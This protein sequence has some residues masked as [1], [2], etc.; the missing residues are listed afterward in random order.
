M[1][2]IHATWD[3]HDYGRNDAGAEFVAK[4]AAKA[5]FLEFSHIPASSP[6]NSRPGIYQ[7]YI[8]GPPGR[9]V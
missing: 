2:S 5:V 1:T 7:A 4:Q 6:V 8:D 3:D 9:R